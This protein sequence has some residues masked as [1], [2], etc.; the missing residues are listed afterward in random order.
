MTEMPLN[1]LQYIGHSC[2]TIR[3]YLWFKHFMELR[4]LEHAEYF[5]DKLYRRREDMLEKCPQ[6]WNAIGAEFDA[7]QA[8]ASQ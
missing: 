2:T 6:T 7:A 8:E 4:R 1:W 3:W 5:L